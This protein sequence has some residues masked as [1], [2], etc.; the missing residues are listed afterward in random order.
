MIKKIYSHEIM[1]LTASFLY[2]IYKEDEEVASARISNHIRW[3]FEL[4]PHG[5][6]VYLCYFR[7]ICRLETSYEKQCTLYSMV[8]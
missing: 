2:R 1:I 6:M 4:D 3:R 7:F 8:Q 5:V